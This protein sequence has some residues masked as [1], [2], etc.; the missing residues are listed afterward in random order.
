MYLTVNDAKTY[1]Y[2]GGKAVDAAKPTV[3]FI[4][5]VLNDHS[6]WILQTRYL[7]NHGW[8]VLAV[9]LPGHCRSAGEP[10]STVEDAADFVIAL[11][12]A[13]GLQK[14]ALVGHSFGSLVALEAASRAPERISQLVLVGIA[15]PM[16]VSPALLASSLSEPMKA[17]EMVNIFSR[18][19]LAPPPSSMGPGTW[20]YGASMALG[21]RVLASNPRVNLFHTGFKACDSYSHGEQAMARV[22]C[23]V[24]FVLGSVDQ[25]TPPKA[26]LGLIKRALNAQVVYLP[27]GHH[28]MTETPDAMLAALNGFLKA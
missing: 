8:N 1:C 23:P 14:A 16:K 4:H 9:D 17:L 15:F 26:A 10:P 25:M 27:G 11:M 22:A 5:G 13:A 7:A 20:V 12:D 6:V 18:A 2:T 21:R 28:Q 24:L 19:T 3:I